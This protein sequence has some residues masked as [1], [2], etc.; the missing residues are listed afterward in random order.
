MA[1]TEPLELLDGYH[2]IVSDRMRD[3]AWDCSKVRIVGEYYFGPES[4]PWRPIPYTL[5]E[6]RVHQ[7][8]SM[9]GVR[10]LV[11]WD[12]HISVLRQVDQRLQDAEQCRLD[13][14]KRIRSVL[15]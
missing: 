1:F 14:K 5:T 7:S 15:L 9:C 8:F 6:E 12:A 13:N 11:S 10:K 4:R 2:H 3:F